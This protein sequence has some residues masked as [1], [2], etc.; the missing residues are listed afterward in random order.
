MKRVVFSNR[1]R[2]TGA[3]YVAAPARRWRPRVGR[4]R[5]ALL[6]AIAAVG[7][8]FAAVTPALAIE[9]PPQA[10]FA[11]APRAAPH[12]PVR[13]LRKPASGAVHRVHAPARKHRPAG[14]RVAQAGKAGPPAPR[15]LAAQ[16]PAAAPAPGES[17]A[18]ML[19]P[20]YSHAVLPRDEACDKHAP[21]A[22]MSL[23]PGAVPA[24][25]ARGIL[26]DI[27]GPTPVAADQAVDTVTPD[28]FTPMDNGV[29]PGAP[30]FPFD[31]GVIPTGVI[32]PPGLP[33]GPGVPGLPGV[34]GIPGVPGLP[35]PPVIPGLPPETGTPPTVLP[36]GGQ[37][38][39]VVVPPYVPPGGPPTGPGPTGAVPE[40]ATWA[41]LILGFFGTGAAVRKARRRLEL[42]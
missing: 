37:P 38:P 4:S 33:G 26:E 24:R 29:F 13:H 25:G 11:P 22:M 10:A 17:R 7:V 9:C 41:M 28:T 15:L 6:S 30:G 31:N 21:L 40:P 2:A 35:T 36:P 19:R 23:T 18:M 34:P 20:G 42:G 39:V 16:N 27:A 3:P 8:G 1:A 32:T 14:R 5:G 12:H